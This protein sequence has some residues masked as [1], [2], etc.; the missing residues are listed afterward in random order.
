MT[1]AQS[2]H[3]RITCN[4]GSYNYDK[5]SG[6]TDCPKN[7]YCL[8]NAG[9]EKNGWSG[10]EIQYCE[11]GKT[12][13][14]IRKSGSD[15]PDNFDKT[16]VYACPKGYPNSDGKAKS[17][18][19]CYDNTSCSGKNIYYTKVTFGPGWY[20]PMCSNNAAKCPANHVCK[21]SAAYGYPDGI[22]PRTKDT[23]GAQKC[24]EGQKPN[25]AQ[26][27]CVVDTGGC[28]AGFKPNTAVVVNP[29]YYL[30]TCENE[31][32]KCTTDPACSGKK[33]HACPGSQSGFWGK[34]P[35][36]D[37]QTKA[38][39]TTRSSNKLSL[40]CVECPAGYYAKDDM[41]ECIECP[42]GQQVNEDFTGCEDIGDITVAPG[43]YLKKNSET[44]TACP[45]TMPSTKYCP[46]GEFTFSKTEDQGMYECPYNSKHVDG[47]VSKCA[48]TLTKEQMECGIKGTGRKDKESDRNDYVSSCASSPCWIKTDPEDYINCIFGKRFEIGNSD[49]DTTPEGSAKK[50]NRLIRHQDISKKEEENSKVTAKDLN[51]EQT[52]EKQQTEKRH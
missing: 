41:T 51:V 12:N 49:D 52:K 22:W 31:A 23:Y 39:W 36:D 7:C 50:K 4:A 15:Q 19:E 1:Y 17:S 5:V 2:V 48:I 38:T 40:G 11:P 20:A 25:A 21:G 10:Y 35:T 47:D 13:S 8:G 44:Q 27:E 3:A 29:G 16:G 33:N 43:Y 24:P 28:P 34:F 14:I 37:A 32:T 18:A 26:T 9:N 30:K 45:P 42:L 46:G 6:C